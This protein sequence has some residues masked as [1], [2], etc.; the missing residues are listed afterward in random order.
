MSAF[1]IFIY[2]IK[3]LTMLK[4]ILI[5]FLFII[6]TQ[7]TFSQSAFRIGI[8]GGIPNRKLEET[9]S[10]H[11][12]A[13]V[14]YK[15]D[16]IDFMQFGAKLGYSRYFGKDIEGESQNVNEDISFLPIA[17]IA[18]LFI[19]EELYAG[20]DL[21]YAIG[22]SEGNN[23]SLYFKPHLGFNFGIFDIIG[24]YEMIPVQDINT[25]SVNI[26]LEF[27]L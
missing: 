21:G 10:L 4:R 8:E 2:C 5:F 6:T 22:L 23:G 17:G 11:T 25:G 19:T 26:G 18:R 15:I 27:Q 14:S 7:S 20:T 13:D 1:F 3:L 12:G 16:V 9:H 24:S